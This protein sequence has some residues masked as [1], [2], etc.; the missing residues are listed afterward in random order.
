MRSLRRLIL[1]LFVLAALALS[2]AGVAFARES[3][4]SNI[5]GVRDREVEFTGT[6][7]AIVGNTW[8]V[9]GRTFVV[10]VS[11]EIKGTIAVG[12]MVKVHAR[13]AAD[14]SLTAS[15]IEMAGMPGIEDANANE[16]MDDDLLEESTNDEGQ[17]MDENAN[18]NE[19]QDEDSLN[20]NS[21]A[22]SNEDQEFIGENT[23]NNTSLHENNANDNVGIEDNSND[24]SAGHDR[25]FKANNNS[26]GEDGHHDGDSHNTGS[27][28]HSGGGGDDQGGDSGGD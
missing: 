13:M 19:S 5:F 24:N 7:Q 20:N 22:N 21:N 8:T 23:N 27:G 2:V 14:G 9:N 15:E 11:T 3:T 17:L 6:V 16:N 1:P 25:E 28:D 12:Q 26:Q 4:V 18:A 10:D